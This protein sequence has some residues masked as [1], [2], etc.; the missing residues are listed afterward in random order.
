MPD[1]SFVASLYISYSQYGAMVRIVRSQS[2]QQLA[3]HTVHTFHAFPCVCSVSFRVICRN[4]NV[5]TTLTGGVLKSLCRVH[6]VDL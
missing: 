1:G 5:N 6:N 3:C 2:F 4:I